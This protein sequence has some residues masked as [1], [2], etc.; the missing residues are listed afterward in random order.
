MRSLLLAIHRDERGA[1][2]IETILIL[3]AVAIPVLIFLLKFGWP[4]VRDLFD[5]G[6][7]ELNSAVDG[8]MYGS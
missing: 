1:A 8:V 5:R 6:D 4:H 3:G 7:S 2:S